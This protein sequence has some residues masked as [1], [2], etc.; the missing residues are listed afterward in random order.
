M[1][2]HWTGS[3]ISRVTHN[4]TPINLSVSGNHSDLINLST[5]A[6]M[7]WSPSCQAHCLKSVQAAP[8]RL[9]GGLEVAPDLSSIPTEHQVLR[10]V[11][12]TSQAT[13]IPPQRPDDCR[14][15]LLP[16]ITLPRGSLYS[17]PGPKTK[18]METYIEHSLATGFICPSSSPAGAGFF[19]EERSRPCTRALTTR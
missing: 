9:P 11:F 3:S 13:S 6:I 8:G 7:G 1:L 15:V 14:I 12:S 4:S 16:S 2:E 19:F 18:A 17:L 5:G 10:E